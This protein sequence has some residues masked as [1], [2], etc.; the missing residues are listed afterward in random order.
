MNPKILI[1]TPIYSEKDYCLEEHLE[2]MAK[3]DYD[4][5]DHI[6]I[7]NSKESESWFFEKLQYLSKRYG[8]K[9]YKTKRGASSRTAINNA[10][11]LARM[12]MLEGDYQYMLVVESDL[13][14][15]PDSLKRLLSYNKRVVGSYYLIGFK[16]D[17]EKYLKLLDLKVTNQISNR[18][19]YMGLQ[20]LNPQ[21]ACI[22][23][24]D[25]KKTGL[26][27]TKGLNYFESVE[28]F[29]RGLQ[30]VH[31]CG[32]GCTLIRRDIIAKFPFWTDSRF[33]NKHHDVYFYLDLDNAGIPVYVDTNVN[34]RHEPSDWLKVQD[35]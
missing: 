16:E 21:R 35:R 23:L 7:D 11:N 29:G 24:R 26:M 4:N 33:G 22:F 3:L 31:G 8:F 19:Y 13:F 30:Q 17:N 28:F 25:L 20:T 1:A 32:L 14:P 5:Y 18:G 12:I 9:A 15:R 34:V 10:M 6:F 2:C 27:G